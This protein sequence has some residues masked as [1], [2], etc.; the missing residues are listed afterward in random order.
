MKQDKKEPVAKAKRRPHYL[1]LLDPNF[2]YVP[3]AATDVQQTW[4]RF[5]WV[6]PER[7][8]DVSDG[9]STSTT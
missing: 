5:G 3:A 8:R 2:K 1:S 4:K 7:K 9:Y 6:P